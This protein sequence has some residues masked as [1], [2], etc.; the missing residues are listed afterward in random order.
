MA[1]WHKTI[2]IKPIIH[3]D[4]MN[5]DPTYVAGIGKEIA[6]LVRNRTTED[7]KTFALLDAVETLEDIDPTDDDAVDVFNGA[8]SELYTWADR[9]RVWLGI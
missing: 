6:E 7:E 4:Q 8:L 9:E 5:T 3:R 1:R 2:D